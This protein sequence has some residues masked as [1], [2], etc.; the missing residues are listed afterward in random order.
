[1][2]HCRQILSNKNYSRNHDITLF[3]G[4]RACEYSERHFYKHLLFENLFQ[5]DVAF[6]LN[7]TSI[8]LDFPFVI[9]MC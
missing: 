5:R 9:T 3:L 1:M 4:C 2:P 7:D 6:L 8:R